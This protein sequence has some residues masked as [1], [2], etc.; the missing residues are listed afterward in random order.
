VET[1]KETQQVELVR[2]A[3]PILA[4]AAVAATALAETVLLE[5]FG[6]G[7]EFNGLLC[8]SK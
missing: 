8:K 3:L 2:L 5:E 1:E 7:T 4:L 6:L